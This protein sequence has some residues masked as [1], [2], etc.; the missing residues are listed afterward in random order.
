MSLLYLDLF[1][2]FVEKILFCSSFYIKV[3]YFIHSS[4][5]NIYNSFVEIVG[6]LGNY[7]NQIT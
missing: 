7:I 6:W 1:Q 3:Q 4:Y 2:Y 5:E